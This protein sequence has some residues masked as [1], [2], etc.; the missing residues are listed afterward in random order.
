MTVEQAM[1]MIYRFFSSPAADLSAMD[2]YED[3]SQVS[4]WARN[5]VAWTIANVVFQPD[6]II[7]PQARITV[8]ELT[9]CLGQIAV[10]C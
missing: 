3:E 4:P 10:A 5:A 6:G 1:V 9:H 2:C 7:S 8:E